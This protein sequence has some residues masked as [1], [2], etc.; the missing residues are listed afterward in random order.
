MAP[1]DADGP[2]HLGLIALRQSRWS[3]ALEA[4]DQA[5]ERGGR[6]PAFLHNRALALEALGRLDE[7]DALLADAVESDRDDPRLWTGWAMLAL[8][9]NES[10][11]A[12]E[13]FARAG[14]KYGEPP[15][16]G[17]LVLGMRL[18]T[19]PERGV[20]R[21]RGHRPRGGRCLS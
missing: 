12:L 7:A 4:L 20:D 10:A 18:G 2:F 15:G 1:D 8:K 14:E 11:M 6:R 19:G 5:I 3:E 9:R 16:T 17:P 21:R 13:R